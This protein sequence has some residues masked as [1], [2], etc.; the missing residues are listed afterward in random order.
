[1]G[2]GLPLTRL[3]ARASPASLWQPLAPGGSNCAASPLSTGLWHQTK[4]LV[5]Q[6]MCGGLFSLLLVMVRN[7]KGIPAPSHITTCPFEGWQASCLPQM[8]RRLWLWDHLC[9]HRPSDL[10][11][12]PS[13]GALWLGASTPK[14]KPQPVGF[15]LV[16]PG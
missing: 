9:S 1:M 7:L 15:P 2:N 8:E 3:G 10:S 13:I 4:P 12:F 14:L 16:P 5:S 11:H 6:H